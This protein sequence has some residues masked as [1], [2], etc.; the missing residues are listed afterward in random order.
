[1]GRGTESIKKLSSKSTI[2]SP[3]FPFR[4]FLDFRVFVH[5]LKSTSGAHPSSPTLRKGV[6]TW[7]ICAPGKDLRAA[8]GGET[9]SGGIKVGGILAVWNSAFFGGVFFQLFRL[10]PFFACS[11][12]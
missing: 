6:P 7:P 8:S 5:W 11:L 3:F 9:V 12:L 2:H 10:K 4:L 1:M